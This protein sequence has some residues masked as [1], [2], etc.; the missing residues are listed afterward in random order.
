MNIER[1]LFDTNLTVSFINIIDN[2]QK[3]FIADSKEQAELR[4]F[5]MQTQY[6]N[7]YLNGLT[8]QRKKAHSLFMTPKKLAHFHLIEIL[9]KEQVFSFD[10]KR[11]IKIIEIL[12]ELTDNKTSKKKLVKVLNWL[13]NK[14]I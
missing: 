13:N 11:A 1:N 12:Q 4:A 2:K 6:I 9:M 7:E 5:E 14:K 3:Q 8:E 10:N